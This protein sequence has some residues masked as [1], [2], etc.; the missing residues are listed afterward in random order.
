RLWPICH[1]DGHVTVGHVTGSLLWKEL[2][3]RGQ[4]GGRHRVVRCAHRRLRKE[5]RIGSAKARTN[6][7]GS[8]SCFDY[9]RCLGLSLLLVAG[10]ERYI[11]QKRGYANTGRRALSLRR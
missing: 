8:I 11:L 3:T 4:A 7:R 9:F 10:S 2:I 1:G 6:V 5:F